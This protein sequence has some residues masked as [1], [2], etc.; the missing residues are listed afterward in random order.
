MPTP[1]PKT[2]PAGADIEAP[3][4]Q[5]RASE[6][7]FDLSDTTLGRVTAEGFSLRPLTPGAADV[8]V[9]VPKSRAICALPDGRWVGLAEATGGWLALVLDPSGQELQRFTMTENPATTRLIADEDAVWLA[10]ASG[11][12]RY[13]LK[14]VIPGVYVADARIGETAPRAISLARLASGHLVGVSG[15]TLERYQ[16]S[17]ANGSWPLP[18]GLTAPVRLAAEGADQL[19]LAPVS[20]ALRRV[21][22]G[23]TLAE[24]QRVET[25]GTVFS[26]AA[27]QGR[28]AW[29][30]LLEATPGGTGSWRV[31]VVDA[32]GARL[33]SLELPAS[34]KR[35][36]EDAQDRELRIS[37][38][39]S[40]VAVGGRGA[41]GAYRVD[42][43]AV[44]LGM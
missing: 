4:P 20:G 6:S 9:A 43:G 27:A 22:L 2:P 32:S 37:P 38:D 13:P 10:T 7:S 26:F 42:D 24:L 44:V 17:A 25:A 29:L 31:H 14:P 5:L 34:G 12:V 19:W 40:V 15:G 28:V 3:R 30:E 21:S 8:R 36:F 11:L 35:A 39:G 1:A 41:L 33:L 16:G 23:E 18:E